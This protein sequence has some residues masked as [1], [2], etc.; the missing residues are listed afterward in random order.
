MSY[1]PGTWA[2]GQ[3]MKV[4]KLNNLE[5]QY[6]C[7]FDASAKTFAG[8]VAVTGV[9]TASDVIQLG[10]ASDTT[11]SRVSAGVIAVE[12]VTVVLAGTSPTFG[13]VVC[14]T[15]DTGQGANEL[16]AMNQNV[17]SSDS[18][19]FNGLTVTTMNSYTFNQSVASGASP[20][21][22]AGNIT[23]ILEANITDG[24]I[25][26][27]LAANETVSGLWSFTNTGV[28]TFSGRIEMMD[29]SN[30]GDWQVQIINTNNSFG[31]ALLRTE[32]TGS[33]G[34]TTYSHISAREPSGS[35]VFNVRGD[36]RVVAAGTMAFGGGS[37]ISSSSNVA[38]LNAVNAFSNTAGTLAT[39][40]RTGSTGVFLGVADSASSAFWGVT[41][42]TYSVQT[43]GGGFSDKLTISAAGDVGIPV[44]LLTVSGFGTHS[45][46]A[47]GT[48]DNLLRVRNTSSS[49]TTARAVMQI[50]ND[51]YDAAGQFFVLSS[52]YATV[53]PEIANAVILRSLTPA[54]LVLAAQDASGDVRIW[55]RNALALAFGAS[56]AATFTGS[57]TM[58]Y[59]LVTAGAGSVYFDIVRSAVD[60]NIAYRVNS[61]T[62][63]WYAGL[64]GGSS[65]TDGAYRIYNGTAGTARF[66]LSTGGNLSITGNYLAGASGS[67]FT[68]DLKVL[69]AEAG[70][71]TIYLW[72]DEG[73]NPADK[74]DI[75][76][77]DESYFRI[78]GGNGNMR[79]NINGDAFAFATTTGGS[80]VSFQLNSGAERY[81]NVSES[82]NGDGGSSAGNYIRL[83]N[84]TNATNTAAGYVVFVEKDGTQQNVWADNTGVMRVNT[85]R[86]LNGFDTAGTVIG[87]QT[88][89]RST[90]NI[91]GEFIDYA[92][93]L[94][95]ILAT[96]LFDFDYK[97]GSYNGQRFVGITTDDSP[98][99]GMD[100]GRSFNPVTAFG[101]TVAAFKE[102]ERRLAVAEATINTLRGVH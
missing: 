48:T 33:A 35:E 15:V 42:G 20:T 96:P 5:T 43:S 77:V 63:E 51:G 32:Y 57:V 50:G 10:H 75:T 88:S 73:D 81:I 78:N 41:N 3:P 18:P 24:S 101:Y 27:R 16:Y 13:A 71:A 100:D 52:T 62:Q 28:T 66:A 7:V 46:T 98:A 90:K 56:Q 85:T 21:F 67:T 84:N 68:T 92:G 1:T 93:A 87:T 14:T 89:Q 91:Y 2:V 69:G 70:S 19:T 79:F 94:S 53:G 23:G 45:F 82:D 64:M 60:V 34:P 37:A 4:G 86:P 25:L 12:G 99:F 47:G 17:R 76:A 95:T 54:G 9:L 22:G 8:A 74:W 30:S 26:A 29:S 102:I 59:G 61:G 97:S 36:G 11:L 72:P 65:S 44:G 58:P 83:G 40:T 38:L 49:G 6:D 55:S 31:T 39:W 80:G